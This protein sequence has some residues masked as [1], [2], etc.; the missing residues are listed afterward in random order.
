MSDGHEYSRCL[1]ISHIADFCPG[2][3]EG[4]AGCFPLLPML[5]EKEMERKLMCISYLYAQYMSTDVE[6]EKIVWF[7]I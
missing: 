4:F 3:R 6:D 1:V 7:K 5:T 2:R